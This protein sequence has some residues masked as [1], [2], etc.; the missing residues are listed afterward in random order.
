MTIR[1][2]DVEKKLKDDLGFTEH[3]ADG[4]SAPSTCNCSPSGVEVEC[5]QLSRKC[6][7]LYFHGTKETVPVEGRD[8]F[9]VAVYDPQYCD[10]GGKE[11]SAGE[12]RRFRN[13]YD[14]IK[15]RDPMYDDDKNEIPAF[16]VFLCSPEMAISWEPIDD[17]H[18]HRRAELPAKFLPHGKKK[19]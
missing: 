13:A 15:M 19:N 10:W 11:A 12:I 5:T 6:V 7:V 2:K 17:E 9:H 1:T 3:E 16:M 4:N 18:A 14:Y 8:P